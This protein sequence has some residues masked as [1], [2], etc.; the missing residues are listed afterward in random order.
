MNLQERLLV[1]WLQLRGLRVYGGALFRDGE[2]LALVFNSDDLNDYYVAFANKKPVP[3]DTS[4]M[5]PENQALTMLK[6]LKDRDEWVAFYEYVV[7]FAEELKSRL[8]LELIVVSAD[9]GIDRL[10]KEC[11]IQMVLDACVPWLLESERVAA[12]PSNVAAPASKPLVLKVPE[13]VA[14]TEP[15]FRS[16]SSAH[17]GQL[18]AARHEVTGEVE[19][20]L[21][22]TGVDKNNNKG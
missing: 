17:M 2:I 20:L 16:D 10:I 9:N 7:S 15:P 18:P 5:S 19:K 11:G 14:A 12:P 13:F 1:Q 21:G 8:K 22:G 3:P 6:F 4:S